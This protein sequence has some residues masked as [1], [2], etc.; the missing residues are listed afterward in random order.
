MAQESEHIRASAE[1]LAAVARHTFGID[2]NAS[3]ETLVN[4]FV[5]ALERL[6]AEGLSLDDAYQEVFARLAD[7]VADG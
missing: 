1:R 4:G 2:S 3:S 7:G 5:K 6:M